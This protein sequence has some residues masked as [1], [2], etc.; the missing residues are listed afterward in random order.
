M[1]QRSDEVGV[2][3]PG[4]NEFERVKLLAGPYRPPRYKIGGKLR[5][6]MRG[7]VV[8]RGIHEAPI[9]WP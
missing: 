8:V 1:N 9:Q 3:N 7:Q 5:C 2:N 4:M 6:A